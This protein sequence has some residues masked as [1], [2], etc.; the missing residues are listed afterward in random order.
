MLIGGGAI[1]VFF[2]LC[3]IRLENSNT[4]SIVWFKPNYGEVFLLDVKLASS[5]STSGAFSEFYTSVIKFSTFY[6]KNLVLDYYS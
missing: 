2:S 4:S 5:K 1:S 3:K 6:F